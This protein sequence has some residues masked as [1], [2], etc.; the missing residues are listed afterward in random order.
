M[1]DAKD[2]AKDDTDSEAIITPERMSHY[3]GDDDEAA[4]WEK[5]FGADDTAEDATDDA[6]PARPAPT[7]SQEPPQ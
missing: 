5:A 1:D 6:A 3:V 2:D 7:P 4:A